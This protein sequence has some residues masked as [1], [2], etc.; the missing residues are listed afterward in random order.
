M[1]KLTGLFELQSFMTRFDDEVKRAAR[2]DRPLGFLLVSWARQQEFQEYSQW[3]AKGYGMLRQLANVLKKNMRDIDVAARVD[4]EMLAALLPETNL[5]G[6]KIV[7]ER[8]CRD[9]ACHEFVGESFENVVLLSVN[10]GYVAFPEHSDD[11]HELL[12]MARQGLEL[13]RQAGF[14]IATEGQKDVAAP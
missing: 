14:N 10:A 3:T 7:A 8:F 13:A 5:A 1:D 4:G 6:T 9:A 2:F 11:A 12:F